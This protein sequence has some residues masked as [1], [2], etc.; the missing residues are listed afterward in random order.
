MKLCELIYAEKQDEF[1]HI[2][3]IQGTKNLYFSRNRDDL[4]GPAQIGD[5]GI[6]AATSPLNKSQ[7]KERCRK[8]MDKFGYSEDLLEIA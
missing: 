7:V 1:D 4:S 8:V 3:S 6:F 2:M 5:S